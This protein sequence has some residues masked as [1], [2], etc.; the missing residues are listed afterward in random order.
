MFNNETKQL[1]DKKIGPNYFGIEVL[2]LKTARNWCSTMTRSYCDLH[3]LPI[4]AFYII[5]H[6]FPSE[7]ETIR[8]IAVETIFNYNI[9]S[10][11]IFPKV[12]QHSSRSV[13]ANFEA[14]YTPMNIICNAMWNSAQ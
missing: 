8:R 9:L 7:A 6:D 3:I 1:Y 10:K 4:D 12:K 13:G 11:D 14:T 2:N 5:L